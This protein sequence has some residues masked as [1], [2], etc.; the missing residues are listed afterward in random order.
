MKLK[1]TRF[2]NIKDGTLGEFEL[3]FNGKIF[4]KGYTLE[5]AGAD[6]TRRGMDRRIL[7]GVYDVA[8]WHSPKFN[9]I[10]PVLFNEQVPRDRCILIHAGN[11]P[12]D[13]EGYILL[14]STFS[15]EGVFNSLSTLKSFLA[16]TLNKE[17]QVEII[18][19]F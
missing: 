6:E 13:T 7:E 16:L 3:L 9:R 5:P 19:K 14:G 10:L 15:D 18:N 17:L 12:K 4:L 11:Y 8:W 2:K 1:I